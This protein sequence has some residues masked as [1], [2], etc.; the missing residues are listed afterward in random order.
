MF[1][2]LQE[3]LHSSLRRL[4][5]AG[6]V[7]EAAL[8]ETLAE[9]R[10]AL[11]EADVS[12]AAARLLCD[13]VRE[14]ALGR[15]VLESI[16]PA[17]Q[18]V[19]IVFETLTE[20]LQGDEAPPPFAIGPPPRVILLVGLQ[21]SGKTTTAAKIASHLAR[22]EKR[23]V[24]LTSLDIYRPAAAEQLRLLAEG[25]GDS[26][27]SYL[28]QDE[29]L[30]PPKLATRALAAAEKR[31]ADTIIL[32]AA[33]RTTLDSEMMDEARDIAK[34]A[35]PGEILL[36]ADAMT[37]QD[38]V[39]LAAGF[40]AALSPS[41][42]VLTRADGDAR[43]GAAL[44]MR[45]VT[46]CPIRFLGTGERLGDL[47]PFDAESL[48][49]TILGMGD[50]LALVRAA[51]DKAD[52]GASAAGA[53]ATARKM[54]KGKF[55]LDDMAEQLSRMSG[56]GFMETMMESL[57]IGLRKKSAMTAPDEKT[58]KRQMAI[59]SSMTRAERRRPEILQASRRR[60]I[61]NGAG[62]TVADVNRLLKQYQTT[63]TL[64]RR[65][66]RS[67]DAGL[68]EMFAAAG[69]GDASGLRALLGQGQ[70]QGHGHS[71]GRG[72]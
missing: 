7:R 55:D 9:I 25:S 56:G 50:L 58:L 35:N 66:S 5:A 62:V 47:Q 31:G 48:A 69:G 53:D 68:R 8:E 33:G 70:G 54:R 51:Q 39:K 34:A 45:H 21:G 18:V 15:E 38:A 71:R 23:R 44:S 43:G 52:A 6:V 61:A 24:A 59:L 49:R 28:P 41:G 22:A 14:R 60:R 1:E 64:V 17:Q 65:L 27:L 11:L 30:A 29:G 72:R 37:G 63:R 26:R 32:D 42:I 16:T 36:V 13:T 67:G 10:T 46:G 3:R 20:L 40:Q 12:L 4:G 57:P 19:Q 2:H